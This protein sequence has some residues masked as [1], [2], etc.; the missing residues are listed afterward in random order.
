MSE[1]YAYWGERRSINYT[2][3]FNSIKVGINTSMG[4]VFIYFH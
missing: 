4:G 3:Y 1:N 2:D